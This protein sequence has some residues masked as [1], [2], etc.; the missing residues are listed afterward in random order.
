MP[1]GGNDDDDGAVIIIRKV[2]NTPI[3]YT[4]GVKVW[5]GVA[6][7]AAMALLAAWLF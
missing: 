2:A 3:P 1:T 5:Q 4:G 7:L 6:A